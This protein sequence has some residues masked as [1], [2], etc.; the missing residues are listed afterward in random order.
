MTPLL[1]PEPSKA[2]PRHFTYLALAMC[3]LAIAH[4]AERTSYWSKYWQN[5]ATETFGKKPVTLSVGTVEVTLPLEFITTSRQRYRALG[6][7]TNFKTLR[8]SM[9]WPFLDAPPL[10]TNVFSDS[11]DNERTILVELESNPG[12]ES[13]RARL[14]PFYRRL[15]RGGEIRG[16]DGLKI[17]TLSSRG[18]PTSDLIVYDPSVQN[19]FIARCL[20]KVATGRSICHRAIVLASGLELRYRFDR[21]LLPDWRKLDKSIIR[22]IASF[23]VN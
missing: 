2:Q 7:D 4:I 13:L 3:V 6:A 5:G 14:D 9:T 22:K 15:A 8:L 20:K 11:A 21:S 12:R 23:R 16:P 19:G 10:H 18:S 1:L 17:L